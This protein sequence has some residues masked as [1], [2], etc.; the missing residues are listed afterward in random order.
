MEHK[1]Q[2][3]KKGEIIMK[4][5]NENAM[6]VTNGGG[7][8]RCVYP[9]SRKYKYKDGNLLSEFA[10]ACAYNNHMKYFCV[11]GRRYLNGN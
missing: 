11:Y 4:K 8:Y 2:N 7:Y 6:K 10:A 5:M 9:C 3:N 1:F